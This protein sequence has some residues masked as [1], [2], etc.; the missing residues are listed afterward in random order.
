MYCSE[1][2][3][4]IAMAVEIV[5]PVDSLPLL[6]AAVRR[7]IDTLRSLAWLTRKFGFSVSLFKSNS[8]DSINCSC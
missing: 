6:D 5:R 2:L 7:K 3:E 8:V 4:W 1:V